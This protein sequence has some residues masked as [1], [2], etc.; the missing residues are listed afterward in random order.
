MAVVAALTVPFSASPSGAA[1]H[2]NT[3]AVVFTPPGQPTFAVLPWAPYPSTINVAGESGVITD[4]NVTFNDF[5][6]PFP[7]DVDVL[8]V[9]PD[10]STRLLVFSDIGGNNDDI[11]DTVTDVDLTFDDE[12]A[13]PPAT[14]GLLTSGTYRP[15]DDDDDASEVFG[16]DQFPGAPVDPGTATA[17][18]IFDGI[19]P[20]GTWSLYVVDDEPGPP[21]GGDFGGGW[22]LNITTSGTPTSSSTPTTGGGSTTTP[23]SSTLPPT[24]STTP[25][26]STSSTSTTVGPTTTTT[27]AT[28]TTQATTTTVPQTTTTQ[29]TTTTVP[30]TTTTT[31]PGTCGG[32]TPTIVGTS[33]PDTLTGT[34]GP[35]VIVGGGGNDSINGLGGDDTICGGAGN[36]RLVGGEGNDRLFGDAGGDQ[37][38]GDNG[39]D[40]LDGG[41]EPDQCFGGN[42]TDT[43]TTC[44]SIVG[45]P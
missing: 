15:A 4:V 45:V 39:N 42:G 1:Q 10:G 25:T 30:G 24:S 36:D 14:D 37:L 7:E 43:A 23:T 6:Y 9:A 32:L 34:A 22:C 2:C 12:A 17:L 28:T 31:P 3:N 5:T 33:G 21:T 26:S 35:D 16:P 29:A 19:N 44:E 40:A 18:S 13:N 8:L 27:I 20:N 11:S 38:I 41:T